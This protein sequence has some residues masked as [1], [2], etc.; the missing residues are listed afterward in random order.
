MS[1][2]IRELG[3]GGRLLRVHS[4]TGSQKSLLVARLRFVA[5]QAR[6]TQVLGSL[7]GPLGFEPRTDG[8]KVSGSSLK[9]AGKQQGKRR[10]QATFRLKAYTCANIAAVRALAAT[11][12]A[13]AINPNSGIFLRQGHDTIVLP[14][15]GISPSPTIL[16]A[17]RAVDGLRTKRR[18]PK[19]L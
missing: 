14:L 15:T 7:V 17:R 10:S 13:G 6:I 5:Y 4:V 11:I 2:D 16:F 19:L 8:L 3:G 12:C 18:H 1:R 9:T